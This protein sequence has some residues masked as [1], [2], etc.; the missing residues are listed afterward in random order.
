MTDEIV[1]CNAKRVEYCIRIVLKGFIGKF[2]AASIY[3]HEDAGFCDKEATLGRR[4]PTPSESLRN[5]D[6]QLGRLMAVCF[7]WCCIRCIVDFVLDFV[8]VYNPEAYASP[9]EASLPVSP[10]VEYSGKWNLGKMFTQPTYFTPPLPEFAFA[11]KEIYNRIP[12]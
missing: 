7:C 5:L 4:E 12:S 6:E 11:S 1:V 10:W 2:K 9:T 3:I 8:V